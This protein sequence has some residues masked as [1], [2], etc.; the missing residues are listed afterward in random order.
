[1]IVTPGERCC[2]LNPLFSV[3]PVLMRCVD[4][5]AGATGAMEIQMT[6]QGLVPIK[7]MSLTIFPPL[8][9]VPVLNLAV[10]CGDSSSRRMRVAY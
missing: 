7:Q 8:L 2:I 10:A 6:V 1:L 5:F 4:C 9:A 3:T